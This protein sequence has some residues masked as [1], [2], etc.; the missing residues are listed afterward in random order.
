MRRFLPAHIDW[1]SPETLLLLMAIAMPLSFASWRGLLN[2]FAVE[3]VN[4]DGKDMGFLQSLLRGPAGIQHGHG[5]TAQTR[6]RTQY[7]RT[8]GQR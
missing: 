3:V 6:A 5:Q 1:R 7:Q 2:N 4:F 8:S